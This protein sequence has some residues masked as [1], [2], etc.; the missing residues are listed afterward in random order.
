[1]GDNLM[2][3]TMPKM[4]KKEAL[5]AK[6]GYC[7]KW[8]IERGTG[9]K[10]IILRKTFD[11][12][13]YGEKASYDEALTMYVHGCFVE[14]EVIMGKPGERFVDMMVRI[15]WLKRDENGKIV[16]V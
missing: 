8:M 11:P 15:G 12:G 10:T 5:L 2:N 9:V 14:D 13:M 1:M 6:H 3:F 7:E 16:E 4:S